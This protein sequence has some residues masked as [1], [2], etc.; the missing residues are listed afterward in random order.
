MVTFL[1]E[2]LQHEQRRF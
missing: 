1:S 2:R